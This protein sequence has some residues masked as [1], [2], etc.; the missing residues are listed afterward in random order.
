MQLAHFLQHAGE[1][2]LFND[3]ANPGTLHE[4][5]DTDWAADEL[6]R[7]AVSCTVE[8]YGSQMLDCSV[9]EQS[10]VCTVLPRG[11][12]LRHCQGRG[13]VRVTTHRR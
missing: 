8:R 12:V 2:W 4:N 1:T 13:D 5:T 6:T 10:F 3:Q 9:A 7:K 11:R